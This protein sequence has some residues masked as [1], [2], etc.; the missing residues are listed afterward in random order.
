MHCFSLTSGAPRKRIL[1]MPH[2][3]DPN[4]RNIRCCSIFLTTTNSEPLVLLRK[5]KIIN[6][7]EI[8]FLPMVPILS[9]VKLLAEILTWKI[10]ALCESL[11]NCNFLS[12]MQNFYRISDNLVKVLSSFPDIKSEI[13]NCVYNSKH[14]PDTSG[15]SSGGEK[16]W[17]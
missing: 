10:C 8:N 9:L 3:F 1:G 6:M 5:S 17:F 2:Y 11:E 14:R 7:L 12:D 4:R 16:L 15:K 13:V